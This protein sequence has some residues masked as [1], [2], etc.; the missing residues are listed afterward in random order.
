M[1]ARLAS[2]VSAQVRQEDGVG[3]D[4]SYWAHVVEEAPAMNHPRERRAIHI[5][6]VVDGGGNEFAD[7]TIGVI[8]VGEVYMPGWTMRRGVVY[9]VCR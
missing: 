8:A 7:R 1:G 4:G 9:R 2:R 6:G 3:C 5:V